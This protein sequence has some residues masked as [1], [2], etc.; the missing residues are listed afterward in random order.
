MSFSL[1]VMLVV[2][3]YVAIATAILAAAPPS[4]LP[5]GIGAAV[6]LGVALAVAYA[7]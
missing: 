4:K 2:V 3:A 7:K 5:V 1:R 6:L